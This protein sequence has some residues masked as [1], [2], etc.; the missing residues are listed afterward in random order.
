MR[1]YLF[2]K[3]R[4]RFAQALTPDIEDA[5]SDAVLDLVEY[6]MDVPSS[7]DAEDP[8]RNFAYAVRRGWW[9]ASK[10]LYGYMSRRDHECSMEDFI[11]Q[12]DWGADN[13]NSFV[14]VDHDPTPDELAAEGDEQARARE[15]LRLLSADDWKHW[16]NAA[17]T[18]RTV[19]ECAKSE[20]VSPRAIRYR[21]E[22]G[23]KRLRQ[24]ADE[25]GLV[26]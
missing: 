26:A 22:T 10:R 24:L 15:V 25:G 18:D 5:V 13:D 4:R 1:D 2:W 20:G 9:V 8:N 6:W 17:L 3:C 11:L 14:Q 23:V 19:K 16:G 21:L 7:I 12:D